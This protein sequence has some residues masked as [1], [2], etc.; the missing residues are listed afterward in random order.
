MSIGAW[1]EEEDRNDLNEVLGDNVVTSQ[2][3]TRV[4]R[5]LPSEV[6]Q[7]RCGLCSRLAIRFF[8]P[9]KGLDQVEKKSGIRGVMDSC[10]TNRK[11]Q[12]VLV[13]TP[14]FNMIITGDHRETDGFNLVPQ[15]NGCSNIIAVTDTPLDF[16]WHFFSRL[17][18]VRTACIV[19]GIKYQEVKDWYNTLNLSNAVLLFPNVL[20]IEEIQNPKG[21]LIG[22]P[23][24]T[25]WTNTSDIE[26]G[27]PSISA[28]QVNGDPAWDACLDPVVEP[29]LNLKFVQYR[30]SY[31]QVDHVVDESGYLLE[32]QFIGSNTKIVTV[33]LPGMPGKFWEFSTLLAKDDVL[34]NKLLAHLSHSVP[35]KYWLIDSAHVRRGKRY[36]KGDMSFINEK[37]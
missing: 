8:P 26:S 10:T 4:A 27:A 3:K 16:I 21:D 31:Y 7:G 32:S 15:H 18:C 13:D 17:Q 14:S 25:I 37:Q 9:R 30:S 36:V 28:S 33:E 22:G 29:Q 1:Q 5:L 35:R 2:E 12:R 6:W 11:S 20:K 24:Y 34:G 19:N 23:W